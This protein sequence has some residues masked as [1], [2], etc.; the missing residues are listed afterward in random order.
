MVL[1]REKSVDCAMTSSPRL[2]SLLSI[3]A[4]M[5][6]KAGAAATAGDTWIFS[7]SSP[8]IALPPVSARTNNAATIA[9]VL[10]TASRSGYRR[11]VARYLLGG[12][13]HRLGLG[14]QCTGWPAARST[15][16]GDSGISTAGNSLVVN[17]WKSF[18]HS[19]WL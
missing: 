11:L 19:L 1:V 6:M 15:G 7:I 9:R 2:S 17:P 5:V 8:L 16:G 13:T 10:M 12:G 4:R 18:A 3:T 14:Y